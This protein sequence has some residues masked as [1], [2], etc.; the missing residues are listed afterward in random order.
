[1]EPVLDQ[2]PKHKMA[3]RFLLVGFCAAIDVWVVFFFFPWL[4]WGVFNFGDS[5]LPPYQPD[6]IFEKMCD[7]AWL[8]A[9]W[10]LPILGFLF[11][12]F[13]IDLIFTANNSRRPPA[14]LPDEIISN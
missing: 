9:A 14:N 13:G 4:E 3:K 7:A 2:T 12:K 1:M 11:V 5:D 8:V 10:L 6:T